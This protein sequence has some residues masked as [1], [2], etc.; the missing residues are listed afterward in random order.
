MLSNTRQR[1]V[2][3]RLD[4]LQPPNRRSGS[5]TG[6]QKLG[7]GVSYTGAD[8]EH[9]AQWRQITPSAHDVADRCFFTSRLRCRPR[10]A[11]VNVLDRSPER[12]SGHAGIA[13]WVDSSP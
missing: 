4:L 11:G 6:R 1:V 8:R 12:P 7:D 5:G 3:R 2:N 10:K 13:V 9:L